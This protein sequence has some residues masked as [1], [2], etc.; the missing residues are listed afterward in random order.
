MTQGDMARLLGVHRVT[1]TKAV[2]KL[3]DQGVVRSFTKREL[4]ITDF[5]RLLELSEGLT[6]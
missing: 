2:R 3:K 4:E 1:V 6:I 5:P